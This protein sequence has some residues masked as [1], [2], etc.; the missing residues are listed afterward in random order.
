MRREEEPLILPGQMAV[1][2]TDDGDT[3]LREVLIPPSQKAAPSDW[4]TLE[5]SED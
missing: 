4:L 3:V 1:V 2:V 5:L